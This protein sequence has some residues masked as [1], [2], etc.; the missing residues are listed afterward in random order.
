MP[1]AVRSAAQEEGGREPASCDK[2]LL[3]SLLAGSAGNFL[4]FFDFALF[5]QPPL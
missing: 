4:E 3:V 1:R 2:K 5:G